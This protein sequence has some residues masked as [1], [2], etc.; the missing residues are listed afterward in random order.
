MRRMRRRRAWLGGRSRFQSCTAARRVR[1]WL[2]WP[3]SRGARPRPSSSGTPGRSIACSCSGSF[4]GS[5]TWARRRDDRRAA[6]RDAAPACGGRVGGHRG[7]ADRD[8]PARVAG[9]LADHRPHGAR[10]CSIQAQLPPALLAPGD[11]VRFVPTPESALSGFSRTG[12]RLKAGTTTGQCRPFRDRPSARPADDGAGPWPL[13][14][15]EPWRSGRGPMDPV[16]HRVANALVG[17]PVDAATL[18]ATLIGPELRFG[19][20]NGRRDRG[21]RS[22]A[23][24]RRRRRA[25][26]RACSLSEWQRPAIWRAPIGGARLRGVRRRR[27]RGPVLGS[28]AT[29]VMSGL[30]GVQGRALRAGDR[31]ALGPA[32]GAREDRGRSL[33]RVRRAARDC[34]SSPARKP[35][36]STGSALDALQRTRFTISAAVRP[37]GIPAAGG[38]RSPDAGSAT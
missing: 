17:N 24:A 21:R 18:E 23:D 22:V 31:V 29:H 9:R 8:L 33:R 5:P 12:V 4:R 13:G 10:R 3:P 37:H 38:A 14:P 26:R 16:A 20:G 19:A 7:H 30:G 6:A 36:T 28:R 11:R 25:D 1:T 32:H 15:S 34:A 35:I 27:R 2:R